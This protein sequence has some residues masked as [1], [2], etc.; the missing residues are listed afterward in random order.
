MDTRSAKEERRRISP[1][2]CWKPPRGKN[3]PPKPM[4]MVANGLW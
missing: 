2:P 3:Y 4:L 1:P